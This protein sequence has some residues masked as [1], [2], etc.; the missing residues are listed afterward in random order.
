MVFPQQAWQ[1][2]IHDRRRHI[3]NL[4]LAELAA[5]REMPN[6]LGPL[7]LTD[8][9]HG[10]GQEQPPASVSDTAARFLRTSFQ[11]HVL[12]LR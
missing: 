1:D 10:F 5:R 11:D 12:G 2:P 4:D 6:L 8:G 7:Q 3:P 9:G